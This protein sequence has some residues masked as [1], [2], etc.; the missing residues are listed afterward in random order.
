[1]GLLNKHWYFEGKAGE[2]TIGWLLYFLFSLD[3]AVAAVVCSLDFFF[4]FCG[5]DS[6]Q[7]NRSG[8]KQQDFI[9]QL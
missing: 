7:T 5:N 6:F 8:H 2:M 3:V 9:C 4:F 1:M